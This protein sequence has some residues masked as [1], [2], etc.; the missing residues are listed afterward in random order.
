V[1]IGRRRVGHGQRQSKTTAGE[2]AF[3]AVVTG[4]VNG[5]ALAYSLAT[6]ADQTTGVGSYRSW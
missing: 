6:A 3:D 4:A 5:D 2:P 1:T